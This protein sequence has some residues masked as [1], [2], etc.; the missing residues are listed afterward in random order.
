MKELTLSVF[1]RLPSNLI[2]DLT[3]N[4]KIRFHFAKTAEKSITHSACIHAHKNTYIQCVTVKLAE[5]CNRKIV[6][7]LD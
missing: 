2:F 4:A 5:S 3:M 7:L 1:Y 6:W